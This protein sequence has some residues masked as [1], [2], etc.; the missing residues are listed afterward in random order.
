MGPTSHFPFV[1]LSTELV[2][3]ILRYAA[4]PTFVTV[5]ENASNNPYSSALSL[6]H[7]SR[8]VRRA[9]L[10]EILRTVMLSKYHNAAA[11]VHALRM[12]DAYVQQENHLPFRLRSSQTPVHRSCSPYAQSEPDIDFSLLGSSATILH[13]SLALDFGS[14]W[15]LY[16]C[17]DFAW[18]SHNIDHKHFASPWNT[19]KLTLVGELTRWRPLM[20]TTEGSAFLASISHLTFLSPENAETHL[21]VT[22]DPCF[23][24]ME[25]RDYPLPEWMMSV[26]WASFK[27]LQTVSLVLPRIVLAGAAR[28]HI[29]E[30]NVD[31]ELLTLSAHSLSGHWVS[32]DINAYTE[33]GE[34]HV[35]SVDVRT[36]LGDSRVQ[37]SVSFDWEEA[38]ACGLL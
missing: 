34:G 29:S 28:T 9:V 21:L 16:G 12:Q 18:N 38:W 35:S 30:E 22:Y 7:V 11:F 20:S 32:K 36:N 15:L 25:C 2:L 26:P 23:D 10:P 3:L 14:L 5:D 8:M 37:F 17:L 24:D 31:V 19:K 6:C 4:R 27:G 1:N 33:S 13:P